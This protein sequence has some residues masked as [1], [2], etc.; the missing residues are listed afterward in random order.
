MR[1]IVGKV[2][3]KENRQRSVKSQ[4][5]CKLNYTCTSQIVVKKTDEKRN[6]VYYKTHY[7]HEKDIRHLRISKKDRTA[8]AEQLAN[9]VPMKR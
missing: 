5:S 3:L 4:G 9:G 7:G 8:I 6:V 2:Q 1:Y